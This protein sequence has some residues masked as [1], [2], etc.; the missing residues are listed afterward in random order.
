[1]SAHSVV[2]IG[3]PDTG[4]TN[5]IG[6][7]W[8]ALQTKGSALIAARLPDRIDYVE[9]IVAHLHQGRFAPRTDRNMDASDSRVTLPLAVR[10]SNDQERLELVVP[11]VSGE[12]WKNAAETN[13]LPRE[14]MDQ[15]ERGDAAMVFVRVRSELNVNPPDWVTAARLMA[16]QGDIAEIDSMPT[17]VMLCEFMRFLREI[18]AVR[19]ASRRRRVAVVVTAWD[20]LDTER[21]AA[22]PLAYI[23]H[24]YPLFSGQLADLVECEVKAFGMSVLGGDV[25]DDVAFRERLLASDFRSAGYVVSDVHGKVHRENDLTAPIAWAVGT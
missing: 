12:I 16:H 10:D 23:E 1:M 11:D 21:S 4:K 20:L 18:F 22:G 5:F 25:R 2:L 15:L 13:E 24:E 14:W 6:G 17:Q 19:K 8:L 7:L 3:G 9:D